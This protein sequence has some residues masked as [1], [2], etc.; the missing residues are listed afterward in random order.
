MLLHFQEKVHS[1]YSG[2]LRDSLKITTMECFLPN[3][4]CL[5]VGSTRLAQIEIDS[6][7]FGVDMHYN[8]YKQSCKRFNDQLQNTVNLLRYFGASSFISTALFHG[9]TDVVLANRDGMFI[10]GSGEHIMMDEYDRFNRSM[11]LHA[12]GIICEPN[13]GLVPVTYSADCVTGAIAAPNGAYGVFHSMA[14]KLV[15]DDNI[16][17][18]MVGHFTKLYGI[19]PEELQLAIFPSADVEVYEVDEDFAALFE[20]KFIDRNFPGKPHI[21]LE[22]IAIRRARDAGIAQVTTTNRTTAWIGL[23]SL[24]GAEKSRMEDLNVGNANGQNIMFVVPPKT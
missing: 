8:L 10:L 6:M 22:I 11:Q 4:S 18:K 3:A 23:E 12:D 2:T 19:K 1:I 20:E 16:I 13:S 9:T 14:K 24:R 15:S 5:A 7:R 17:T 21:D